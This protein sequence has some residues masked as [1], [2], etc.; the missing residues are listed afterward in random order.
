MTSNK[1]FNQTPP[2]KANELFAKLLDT[3]EGAV[4][5]REQLFSDLK[6]EL[7]LL[8]NVQEQ[9]LFPVLRK[10]KETQGLVGEALRDN[11]ETKAL[12]VEL[13]AMPKD[14]EAFARKVADL[15]KV[16]Q[17]HIRDDKKELLPV[18]LKVLSEE[19]VDAV[20]EKIEGEIAEV[21]ATKRAEAENRRATARRARDQA[22]SLRKV[23]E[24]TVNAV[25]AGV[26]SAQTLAR[27]ARETMQSSLST[28]SQTAQRSTDQVVQ[29]FGIS[30][31]GT[32]DLAERASQN[33]QA[34]VR[35]S[36]ILARGAGHLSHEIFGMSQER[37]LKNIDGLNA[38][39]GCRS[40]Q[41]LLAVQSS[42]IRENL[43]QAIG[44]SRL[45]LSLPFES[46][47]K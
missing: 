45:W 33:L 17:Q 38:L 11:Q 25:E 12:L 19:E 6:V 30:G 13:E 8:A 28:A 39:L 26:E 37:L 1:A 9:H 46:P 41:D 34:V 29:L 23:S 32:Q 40:I 14:G 2:D 36:T 16:F 4:K 44:N 47:T 5:T 31:R 24:S 3:S 43:D 22:E 7:E 18:V 42:L 20:V 35:S 10:H 27:T 15:R 21:E